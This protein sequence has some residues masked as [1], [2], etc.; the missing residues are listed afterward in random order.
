M[1]YTI[2]ICG[3]GGTGKTTIASLIIDWLV[4]NRKG[5]SVLAIDADP[6]SNLDQ[7]LGIKAETSIVSIVDDISENPDQV[8]AGT[9][10]DR[11][12][13]YKV[14]DALIESAGFDLLA[15]GHPEGPGCYCFVNNLLRALISRLS[16]SYQY[17]VIDNQAGMEHLSRRTA[18]K[19]DL[20][21][22]ISDYSVVG[23]RCAKIILELTKKL[24]IDV[25]NAKLIINRASG[26][27]EKLQAEIKKL[28]IPLAGIVPEDKKVAEA[29]LVS[30]NT[31][32]LEKESQAKKAINRIC[33]EVLGGC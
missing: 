8:P 14:Q 7:A 1:S 23:L 11:Y 26:A 2:A 15:M 22:L 9:S 4:N 29:S 31:A 25:K 32:S 6:N 27:A 3:K 12:L 21:L 24:K 28:D 33:E 16:K 20:L 19:I 13:E 30:G 10:K 17:L 18:R 5:K